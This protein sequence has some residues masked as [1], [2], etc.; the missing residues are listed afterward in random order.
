MRVPQ[1]GLYQ[2]PESLPTLSD[3][4]I[5][6]DLPTKI[7]QLNRW[8]YNSLLT[9]IRIYAYDSQR[10]CLPWVCRKFA[11]IKIWVA[12]NWH[13]RLASFFCSLQDYEQGHKKLSSVCGD[14][15]LRL[16]IV[17]SCAAEELLLPDDFPGEPLLPDNIVDI[18][19]A[20]TSGSTVT[21]TKPPAGGSAAV[22][23]LQPSS[24]TTE[25]SIASPS[26]RFSN[27]ICCTGWR[28][29]Q[30]FRWKM[31]LRKICYRNPDSRNGNPDFPLRN[32][33]F[34]II[35]FSTTISF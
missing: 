25:S 3:E 23:K 8:T 14:V 20:I 34:W 26:G 30:F 11:S 12:G 5:T 29:L 16:S 15:I 33:R 28:N 9:N 27:Q 18:E 31:P 35:H 1:I 19:L 2:F 10:R 4:N 13:R 21:N 24:I 6:S 22:E 7:F 32:N 17:L